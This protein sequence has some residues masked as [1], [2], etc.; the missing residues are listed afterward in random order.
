[1]LGH[2]K[3]AVPLDDDIHVEAFPDQ[4]LLLRGGGGDRDDQQ[5]AE[6]HGSDGDQTCN[7]AGP[8]PAR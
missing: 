6:Q 8:S 5:R 1:M 2:V 7:E 4:R 3:S